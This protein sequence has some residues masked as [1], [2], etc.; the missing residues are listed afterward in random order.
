MYRKILTLATSTQKQYFAY[1]VT[2]EFSANTEMNVTDGHRAVRTC[3]LK[4]TLRIV[5]KLQTP[6]TYTVLRIIEGIALNNGTPRELM[7][8][9]NCRNYGNSVGQQFP[10]FRFSRTASAVEDL[11][12]L[13]KV[14]E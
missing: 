3:M 9:I 13:F 1:A 10:V 14:A 11:C 8:V 4:A 2:K 6:G 7:D 5:E 12:R